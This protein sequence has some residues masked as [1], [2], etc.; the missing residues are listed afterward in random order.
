[1]LLVCCFC[2]KV[3]D[4]TMGQTDWQELRACTRFRQGRQEPIVL[5]YTCCHHCLQRHPQAT[6]FRTRRN[7]STASVG[8]AKARAR[9]SL[10]A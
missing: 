8:H 9:Q 7:Q 6:A 5:S 10:A 1:M 2:D 3:C 4:D